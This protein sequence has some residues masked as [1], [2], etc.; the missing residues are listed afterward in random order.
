M[1]RRQMDLPISGLDAR[2]EDNYN[3]VALNEAVQPFPFE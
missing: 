3:A 1:M 2:F